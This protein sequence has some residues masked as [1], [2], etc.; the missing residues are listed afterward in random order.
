MLN[1]N[2]NTIQNEYATWLNTLGFSSGL[3]YDYK[4]RARD[5]F[6]WAEQ[7]NIN[8]ISS[9]TQKHITQ[10]FEYLQSRPNKRRKGGLSAAHLNHNYMAI[11]KLLEFLHQMGMSTAPTPT[12]HRIKPDKEQRIK[13][14]HPL[15]QQEIKTLQAGIINTYSNLNFIQQERKHEQLK[16]IFALYYGCGL[17]RT[18]GFKL[19]VNDIDFDKKTIFIKQGKGYKDRIVPMNTSVCKALEHYIYNFRNLQKVKHK[20]LFIQSV[21]KVADSLQ[22]LQNVC[23]DEAIQN[24]RLTL[25]I[26]RH[27]IATHLLQNGM[28]I[29][30][31]AR[32]LGHTSLESTQIYTHLV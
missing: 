24:K 27:S 13:N 1:E 28:S 31:I 10:Y 14:I 7:N 32:F 15:T 21:G 29:E 20:R 12:N 30:S 3:V 2:Y 17:R 8:H 9:L 26:L 5:F 11:D 18:E 23:G 6:E 22:E 25:H 4:F 19:T 16:L